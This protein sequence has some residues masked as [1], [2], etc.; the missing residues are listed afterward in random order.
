[1]SKVTMVLLRIAGSVVGLLAVGIGV[2]VPLFFVLSPLDPEKGSSWEGAAPMLQ[3]SLAG[4]AAG[5]VGAALGATITQHFL[6]QRSSFWRALLWAVAGL[7]VGVLCGLVLLYAPSMFGADFGRVA[8]L[9]FIV[10][11]FILF[12]TIVAGAVIGSGWKAMPRD[13][14]SPSA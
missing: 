11:P 4:V 1:M 2:G 5:T 12:A 14:V 9:V 6:R 3:G 13:A 7:V 8:G 10:A